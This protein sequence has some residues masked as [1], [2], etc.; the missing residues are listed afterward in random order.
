MHHRI[1]ELA[2]IYLNKQCL[3]MKSHL[4]FSRSLIYNRRTL[5]SHVIYFVKMIGTQ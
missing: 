1:H 4:G 5:F 2:T 3:V